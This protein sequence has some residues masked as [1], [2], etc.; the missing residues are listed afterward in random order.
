MN[1]DKRNVLG[2]GLDTLLP[3]NRPAAMPAPSLQPQGDM[4]RE[5]AIE[6]IDRNPY[7]TRTRFDEVSMAEL[8]ESI[9]SSGVIQPIMVRPQQNGRFQLIA[10]ERRWMASQKA[11]KKTIP[12]IAKN[13]SNEQA[14]EITIVENLQREDLNA[15]EQARA[16]ERLGR[17]FGLTQEQM[18]QRTGKDRSS[19]SNFLR[20]LKLPAEVQQMVENDKLTF[21][22]AK[23]LM[24][25][26][27][28]EAILKLA[29]RAA[30][31]S[32]S[33]RQV[34][35]AVSNL[36]HP[37]EKVEVPERKV[38]PNV[39]EAERE[40]ERSLGVKVQITDKNGRGKIQIEYKTLEDF[41]RVLDALGAKR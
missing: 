33:V 23:A 32:M 2:R 31:L 22:H 3:S 9:K 27:S 11:G 14:M 19:V 39:R 5:I 1:K 7:Q 20:L 35:G 36:M 21:G 24:S 40:L 10:G 6:L 25:L 29:Q 34:E 13:V 4:V 26:D 17:E 16:Y 41:D 15:M 38:D 12:V 8:A 37:A 28:P 18:A 30:Q